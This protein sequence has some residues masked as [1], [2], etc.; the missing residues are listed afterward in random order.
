MQGEHSEDRANDVEDE[1]VPT[2]HR[3]VLLPPEQ[4]VPGRHGIPSVIPENGHRVLGSHN[5]HD[6]NNVVFENVPAWQGVGFA[7]PAGHANPFGHWYELGAS[8]V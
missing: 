8:L 5:K 6:A 1:K 7:E 4:N 3:P 2:G